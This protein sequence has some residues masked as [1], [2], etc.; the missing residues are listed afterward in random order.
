M[1]GYGIGTCRRG[2]LAWDEERTLGNGATRR[3]CRIL[4][5]ASMHSY[6][7]VLARPWGRDMD[8]PRQADSE[9]LQGRQREGSSKSSLQ[10][11]AGRRRQEY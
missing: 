8:L 10:V 5:M 3:T 2:T 9:P 11:D 7:R 1:S 4:K 6:F